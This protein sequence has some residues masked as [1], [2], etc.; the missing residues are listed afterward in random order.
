MV[1]NQVVDI[2]VI[3]K[4]RDHAVNQSSDPVGCRRRAHSEVGRAG[5]RTEGNQAIKQS[6]DEAMKRAS[7][8]AITRSRTARHM[9]QPAWICASGS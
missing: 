1:G 9:I 6:S 2:Q 8:R 5:E 4:S 3:T 7:D